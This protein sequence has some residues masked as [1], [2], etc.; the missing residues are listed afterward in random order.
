M[1]DGY[2]TALVGLLGVMA[3]GYLNN[4]L[5]EDYRRFRD[6]QALAGAL[7]GELESHGD[8][9]SQIK[10][11]LDLII[12][13]VEPLAS[14][15]IPEWPVPNSP[16]FE[17]YAEKI[18]L[19]NPENAKDVAY[20]YEHIRAFRIAIN[21]LSKHHV[22]MGADWRASMAKSCSDAIGRAEDRGKP[23]VERLKR[24][25]KASYWCR[26][27]TLTQCAVG[28]ML[29]AA[30]LLAAMRLSGPKASTNCVTIFDHAKGVLSTVCK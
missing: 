4:F 22:E 15:K 29:V 12:G 19:L 16:V 26:P 27:G 10:T 23:L 28:L 20:V 21:M 7:A 9:A 24:H 6:S 30:L 18:G 3:G 17:A 11:S 5:A 25:A 1:A 8:A 14:V 2:S 13:A